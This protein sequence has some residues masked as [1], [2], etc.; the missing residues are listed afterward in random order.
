M[1]Q[2]DVKQQ[3]EEEEK[4][5]TKTLP[6]INDAYDASRKKFKSRQ[7]YYDLYYVRQKGEN[8]KKDQPNKFLSPQYQSFAEQ[9][10]SLYAQGL[11]GT[12]IQPSFIYTPMNNLYA[13]RAAQAIT[14]MTYSDLMDDYYY[15]TNYKT[16]FHYVVEGFAVEKPWWNREVVKNYLPDKEEIVIDDFGQTTV[17]KV[18]QKP[19]DKI[20]A[21]R[22]SVRS[23]AP[24]DIWFDPAARN[25][26]ELRYLIERHVLPLS[27]VLQMGKEGILK[28]TEMLKDIPFPTRDSME[29]FYASMSHERRDYYEFYEKR[30]SGNAIDKDDPMIELLVVFRRG[31]Y[32]VIGQEK[33]LLSDP[34]SLPWLDDAFPHEFYSNFPSNYQFEG[35][36]DFFFNKWVIRE[37]D[38]VANLLIKNVDKHLNPT[39]FVNGLLPPKDIAAIKSGEGNVVVESATSDIV[40]QFRPDLPSQSVVNLMD[41][42]VKTAQDNMSVTDLM[43]NESPGSEF[44]TT[45]SIQIAAQLGQIRSAVKLQMLANRKRSLGKKILALQRHNMTEKRAIDVGGSLA[46]NLIEISR[47]DLDL[48]YKVDVNISPAADI[49]RSNELQAMRALF[50]DFSQVP[51]FRVKVAAQE[52]AAK[53]GLF[54]DP[55]ALFTEDPNEIQQA[56]ALDAASMGVKPNPQFAGIQATP[57]PDAGGDSNGAKQAQF[58]QPTGAPSAPAPPAGVEQQ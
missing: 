55:L 54:K 18:K 30:M 36:S 32:Y 8:L 43:A 7:E 4:L 37:A 49:L 16:G 17:R 20:I 44:R 56:N 3:T 57:S 26:R 23:I 50:S 46:P 5:I 42:M 47:S 48:D 6:L 1:V 10:I 15:E 21:N 13:S 22:V 12:N 27:T 53:S 2:I 24:N 28:N 45:G 19:V 33:I 52:M 31:F 35:L 40:T 39:T 11:T 9:K 58:N 29:D 14:A 51:G 41:N 25:E 38:R 34:L